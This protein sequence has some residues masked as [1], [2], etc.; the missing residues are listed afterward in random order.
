MLPTAAFCHEQWEQQKISEKC[1]DD[2]VAV[3]RED[4]KYTFYR[5]GASR[6]LRG[7]RV[8]A[9]IFPSTFLPGIPMYTHVL[10]S[11]A[12]LSG[13]PCKVDQDC[14]FMKVRKG[15]LFFFVFI[16]LK[17]MFQSAWMDKGDSYPPRGSEWP[18]KI[19]RAILLKQASQ[20]SSR[21]PLFRIR[22]KYFPSIYVFRT[23][24]LRM[25]RWFLGDGVS[26]FV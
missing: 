1:K 7:G 17:E 23:L 20:V 14:I 16:F 10:S 6:M 26:R 9:Y 4:Q 8:R 2:G 22:I 21:Q 13:K 19:F 15:D 18:Y 11:W 24:K 25:K 12:W 5:A 3:L